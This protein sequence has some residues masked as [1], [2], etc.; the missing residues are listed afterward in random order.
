MDVRMPLRFICAALSLVSAQGQR[1]EG[2]ISGHVRYP[3]GSPSEA[4]KVIAV[5]ECEGMTVSLQQE[6]TTAPDGSF[7]VSHFS[8]EC[9]KVRLYAEKTDDLWLRTG[10]DEVFY[11]D[12]GPAPLVESHPAGPPAE[13]DIVLGKQGGL[14]TVRVWDRATQQ[15]VWAEL[16]VKREKGS[17]SGIIQK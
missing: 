7:H 16:T 4:A 9:P 1:V 17:P 6:T 13:A 3:D 2:G 15:F 12:N 8:S 5:T 14:L 10:N 11:G